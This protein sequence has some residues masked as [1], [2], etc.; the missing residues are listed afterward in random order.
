MAEHWIFSYGSLMWNPG[1]E[2]LRREKAVLYGAHRRFCVFSYHHRGTFEEPGLV[3]GLDRGGS[4]V[5]FAYEVADESWTE[6]YAYLKDREQRTAVYREAR[7]L[8]KLSDGS[9][10]RALTYLVD[11]RHEQY[12]GPLPLEQQAEM[13]SRACGGSGPNPDYLINTVAHLRSEGIRDSQLEEVEKAL[14]EKLANKG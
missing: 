9:E 13:I 7:R 8:I 11:E 6:V 12:A 1:F 14:L 4:C 2:F 3:L 5:G 10:K